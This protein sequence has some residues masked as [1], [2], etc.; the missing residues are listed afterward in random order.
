MSFASRPSTPDEGL[1]RD[2][3]AGE[4][5]LRED[6]QPDADRRHTRVSHEADEQDTK[7]FSLGG[8]V[9]PTDLAFG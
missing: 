6:Q 2:Q 3:G 9:I 5:H 8:Y 1:D 4:E 7:R